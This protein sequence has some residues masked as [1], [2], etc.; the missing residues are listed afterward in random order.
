ML[1]LAFPEEGRKKEKGA[2]CCL[3]QWEGGGEGG[4]CLPP[5][6]IYLSPCSPSSS[7]IIYHITLHKNIYH[8]NTATFMHFFFLRRR[9]ARK[10]EKGA[11][12]LLGAVVVGV[13]CGDDSG[14]MSMSGSTHG[15]VI[16]Y[17]CNCIS[18][19]LLSSLLSIICLPNIYII[20]GWVIPSHPFAHPLLHTPPRHAHTHT[21]PS[22]AGR[23]LTTHT[24]HF[25]C[26]LPFCL[27]E[28]FHSPHYH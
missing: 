26:C 11:L 12:A 15:D 10:K 3:P 13:M 24:S 22:G 19:F 27:G 21:L 2:A 18:N 16:M 23:F 1:L 25:L 28:L 14:G 17:G 5:L 6:L 8:L 9:Q 20:L 4:G 7:Y